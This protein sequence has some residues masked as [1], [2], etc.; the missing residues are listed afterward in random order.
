MLNT[1]NS[2]FNKALFGKGQ[3]RP[4]RDELHEAQVDGDEPLDDS[5]CVLDG[6]H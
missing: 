5:V 1:T 6:T 2:A 3:S 4:G